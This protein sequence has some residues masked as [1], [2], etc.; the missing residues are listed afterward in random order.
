[1][2][3]KKDKIQFVCQSCGYVAIKWLG[4]CTECGAWN[5]FVEESVIPQKKNRAGKLQQ[6]S[7]AVPLRDISSL[8]DERIVFRS[9]ELNRVL[10]HGLVKGSL[11]LIGG[12]PGI[13]K[14]TLLLQEAAH[15]AAPDFQVLYVS[16]EES[17]QQTK[18]RATRLGLDSQHLLLLAE[19]NLEAILQV[20]ENSQPKMIVVDSVQTIY[21]PEMESAPGSIS[22]VRE[23]ALRFLELAKSKNIPVILVGHVTKEGYLAGPKVLE[24]MVDTLLQFEGDRQQFF[25][26]L[27]AVKNRFGSTREIGIFEMHESGMVD[28]SNPSE[29]FLSQRSSEASGSTVVCA[30]EGTRPILVEVQALVTSTNYGT[31]QRTATG[32]DSKRLALLLAVL[33]KRI[34][35]RLGMFDVFLNVAGGVRLDEPAVDLGI[36]VAI[37][38]SMKNATIPQEMVFV[39]EVGLTGEVRFVPQL[40]QRV[41]EAAKLG[42][43][44]AVIPNL[45][46]KKIASPKNFALIETTRLDDLF[47]LVF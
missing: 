4:R 21:Q 24:H 32:F 40:E 5:S 27:R 36:V 26:I 3:P 20:V 17:N 28:V 43:K 38:S 33:E 42:F 2:S 1:M 25:R 22:Q 13:G 44:K 35:L 30:I 14:S 15:A 41:N 31:P 34:G 39:G 12:D 11:V 29:I 23:C 37:A 9:A 47:D 7:Q 10:G 16:G 6:K 19:T 18:L 8:E 45:G 46:G